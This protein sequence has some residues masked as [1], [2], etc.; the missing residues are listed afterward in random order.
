MKRR[1]AAVLLLAWI[2]AVSWF[3]YRQL[4]EPIAR[5]IHRP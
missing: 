2:A 5:L 4:A 3:H 1:A